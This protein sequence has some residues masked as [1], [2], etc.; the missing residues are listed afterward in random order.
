M[1]DVTAPDAPAADEVLARKLEAEETGDENYDED[2]VLARKLQQ[3]EVDRVLAE[4]LQAEAQH[5]LSLQRRSLKDAA[6]P[7]KQQQG[8]GGGGDSAVKRATGDKSNV[9]L[10]KKSSTLADEVELARL[11]AEFDRVTREADEK[12]G[13][14]LA[15]RLQD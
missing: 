13:L 15:T 7:A 8:G 3:E 12:K 14:K 6:P 11:D 1:S 5:K 10:I 9:A 2:E 4:R